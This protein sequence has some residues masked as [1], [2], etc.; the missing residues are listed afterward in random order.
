MNS[1][2]TVIVYSVM[3]QRFHNG[4]ALILALAW[5]LAPLI[6]AQACMNTHGPDCCCGSHSAAEPVSC[7]EAS[8]PTPTEA[9]SPCDCA[10]QS[11]SVPLQAEIGEASPFAPIKLAVLPALF[12]E[13]TDFPRSSCEDRMIQLRTHPPNA[14]GRP[15]YLQLSSLLR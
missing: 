13:T 6:Q 8:A 10:I 3:R 5:V 7:C 1:G 9:A 12:Y 15:I 2:Q 14:S 4:A 11:G